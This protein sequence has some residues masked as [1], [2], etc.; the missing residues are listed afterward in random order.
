MPVPLVTPV[1]LVMV[2]ILH[3]LTFRTVIPGMGSCTDSIHCGLAPIS[4]YYWQEQLWQ[5]VA[6]CNFRLKVSEFPQIRGPK[7]APK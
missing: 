7:V 5:Y 6:I 4:Q 1:P 2:S 3:D